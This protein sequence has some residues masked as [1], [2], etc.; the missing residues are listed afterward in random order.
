M[1]DYFL[2]NKEDPDQPFLCQSS[3]VNLMC[4][5][6]SYISELGNKIQT[7]SD[8]PELYPPA[9][10][11]I[12]QIERCFLLAKESVSVFIEY[13]KLSTK[14]KQSSPRM[15]TLVQEHCV[16]LM[17][18][19]LNK[20]PQFQSLPSDCQNRLLR[21]NMTEVTV[22]LFTMSFERNKQVF[23]WSHAG[24]TPRTWFERKDGTTETTEQDISKLLNEI[25]GKH[26]LKVVNSLAEL[27]LPGCVLI[28]L[29]IISIFSREGTSMEQQATVDQARNYYRQLLYLYIKVTTSNYSRLNAK[30]HQVLKTVRDLA[31]L[32]R[33]IDAV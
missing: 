10:L 19:F 12:A 1:S 15:F 25:A 26:V 31:E 4:I 30:L 28:L 14:E 33:S 16:Q 3:P 17:V 6:D 24:G 20:C 22:L 11:K 27:E 8:H 18:I 13:S 7:L 9:I 2:N 5:P 32:V 23:R 21:K 29:V